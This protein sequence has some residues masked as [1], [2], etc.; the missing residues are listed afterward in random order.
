MDITAVTAR[1]Q[2][3]WATGDFHRIGVAQVGVGER[4]VRSLQVRAGETVLDIA[5][6]AGNTALAAARRWAKVTATDY[7]PDLLTRAQA[8]AA[9]EGL[10]LTTGVADAQALPY[11]DTSYDVATSTFGVMFAPDQQRAAVEMLRVVRP[12]GRIGLASWTPEG[13]IGEMFALG[14]RYL[15]PPQGVQPASRWGTA[16]GL[17]A[18]FGEAVTDVRMRVRTTDF[19][20]PSPA[21]M[22]EYFRT[23]FGPTAT[24]FAALDPQGQAALADDLLA[25]YGRH[26]TA[27]DGTMLARAQYLEVVAVKA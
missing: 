26:N 14:A 5:S 7:V 17:H 22:L 16:E 1:Q 9:A 24:Q 15:P 10:E 25:L 3:M 11:P 13:L 27:T 20:Y 6:G 21:F 19:V 23:W 4:L 2:T 8:R 18:L 12:D